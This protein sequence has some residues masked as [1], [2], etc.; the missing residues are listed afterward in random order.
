M[1]NNLRGF[2]LLEMIAVMAI[3]SILAGSLAPSLIRSWQDSQ[4]SSE[5][6]SLKTLSA[7]L[8]T[9]IS[10]N[11]RI[12]SPNPS[13][14]GPALADIASASPKNIT[15]NQSGYSRALFFDPKFFTNTET[16]F[17][18]F[19]QNLG[20]LAKPASPRVL[21]VSNLENNTSTVNLNSAQFNA[22][23]NEDT[24]SI[25]TENK[26]LKVIR[27]NLSSTFHQILLT[28]SHTSN[29]AFSLD[30]GARGSVDAKSGSTDGEE[31]RYVIKSSK[32]KLYLPPYPTGNLQ[33]SLLIDTSQSFSFEEQGGFLEWRRP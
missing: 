27:L 16:S 3:T 4:S 25:F 15:H 28:N 20:L 12:P 9:Y 14:W 30:E 24:G 29:A 33:T 8:I 31:I 22:I 21:L 7:T 1:S 19:T 13:S 23:W 32:L 26:T 6:E 18:G 2:S 17:T 11:K 10:E 5:E